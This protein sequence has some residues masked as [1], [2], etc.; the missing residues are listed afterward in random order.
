MR[1][2]KAM[3]GTPSFDAM[4][5]ALHETGNAACIRLANRFTT[6]PPRYG[7]YDLH[8]RDA[9]L[10]YQNTLLIAEAMSGAMSESANADPVLRSFSL[11]YNTGITDPGI[12]AL[13]RVLPST[14]TELGL[15]SCDLGDESGKAILDWANRAKNLTMICVEGNHFSASIRQGFTDISARR[16]HVI[17]VV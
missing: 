8:L 7:F 11:S 5:M 15:V 13:A 4:V 16:P 10:S 2:D 6:S 14:L 1:I 12:I 17:V 3:A 9:G